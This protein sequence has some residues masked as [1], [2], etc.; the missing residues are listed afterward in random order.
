MDTDMMKEP[1]FSDCSE[2][3]TSE[4]GVI[5]I[6]TLFI[7]LILTAV[8]MAAANISTFEQRMSVS[9]L[10]QDVAFQAAESALREGEAFVWGLTG[11]DEGAAN[12]SA[13]T[14]PCISTQ[15]SV[16]G[17]VFANSATLPWGSTSAYALPRFS[18][19]KT[20]PEYVIEYLQRVKDENSSLGLGTKTEISGSDFYRVTARGT[21]RSD[22]AQA[23]VQ[24]V[25]AKRF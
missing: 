21:G 19:V 13:E 8:G 24:S 7:L 14:G 15:N 3:R 10:D 18:G 20:T 25:Y 16:N 4:R 1:T 9:L 23:V 5:L 17:G 12:C 22:Q 11:F 6:V 2:G